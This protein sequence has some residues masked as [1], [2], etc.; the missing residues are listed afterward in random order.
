MAA[1]LTFIIARAVHWPETIVILVAA[2]V[3]GYGGA[4]I[5]RRAPPRVVRAGTMFLTACFTLAFFARA[6]MP[7][8]VVIATAS[9]LSQC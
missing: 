8:T 4:Q 7:T 1:V 3:G 2:A 6:Y 9:P 5:G